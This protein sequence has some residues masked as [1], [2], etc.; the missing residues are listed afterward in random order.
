MQNALVEMTRAREIFC[1]G[2]MQQGVKLSSI[3]RIL[4]ALFALA[5]ADG[6]VAA[7]DDGAIILRENYSFPFETYE[8]WLAFMDRAPDPAWRSETVSK[9]VSGETFERYRRGDVVIAE[10]IAYSSGG[11]RING[12]LVRPRTLEGPAPVILF[13]HGGVAEWGRITFF[14]ILEF[15]RLAEQGYVVLAS[16]LR[17]EGGSEGAPNLGAGDLADM[18]N[19]INVADGLKDAD[20]DRIGLLGFSRG[21]GLGYRMIAAT[22]RIGAAVLI[23]APTDLIKSSRREEFDTHVYPGVVDGYS[24]DRDAA[25]AA[26][27]ALYWPERLSSETALLLLHGQSDDRVATLDSLK[28]A[29]AFESLD[30]PYQLTI[31]HGGSHSLIEHWLSVRREIDAWFSAHLRS[32]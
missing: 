28:I 5:S 1:N 21:G 9:L 16:A 22:D 17:G 30:R 6:A 12:F 27:S 25:L 20:A 29:E 19:L 31:Y 23:G 15:H 2:G 14:D 7:P 18:L 3:V 24:A 13:A 11:L 10:R 4:L 32:E 8:D 26:L